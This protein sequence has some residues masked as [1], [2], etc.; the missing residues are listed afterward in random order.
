MRKI[1]EQ[2]N[3]TVL[4]NSKSSTFSVKL[5]TFFL[6]RQFYISVLILLAPK[7]FGFM[8]Q[9]P[10]NSFF[11]SLFP[12]LNTKTFSGTTLQATFF[13]SLSTI[14]GS[15]VYFCNQSFYPHFSKHQIQNLR[16]NNYCNKL[17]RMSSSTALSS[18]S[19]SESNS[20]GISSIDIGQNIED[21]R[22]RIVVAK[23]SSPFNQPVR[24]VAVSKTKPIELLQSAYASGQRV[25]GENYVHEIVEKS[26]KMPSDVEWHFIGH[27][28]SNKAK[29]LINGVPNL[30]MIETIDSKKLAD[31]F[32]TAL[33]SLA[34]GENS[35]SGDEKGKHDSSSSIQDQENPRIVKVLIQVDTS[36]ED[37]KSGVSVEEAL[38]LAKHIQE[39]CPFLKFSG[40]MTIGAPGDMSCFDK[41]V[42][43]RDMISQSLQIPNSELEVS[44]GM[45]SDFEEA[46]RKGSTNVRPGTTI[47]G[48][49]NYKK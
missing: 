13:T 28:Q 8:I 32:N 26:P 46:I 42:A 33:K 43:C 17:Y 35:D 7:A 37:T 20:D 16:V 14:Q 44:M 4:S 21:V 39:S 45:S 48:A 41:L 27:V 9:T 40:V 29:V 34:D 2:L 6:I 3:R 15:S 23:E 25:F 12:R 30:S 19:I 10:R 31:K 49:R 18:T 24:L 36:G 5:F 38:E 47:F 22:H 1:H 11:K